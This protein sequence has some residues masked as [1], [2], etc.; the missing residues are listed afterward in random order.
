MAINAVTIPQ[1]LRPED[2]ASIYGG[3]RPMEGSPLP[4]N[5]NMGQPANV[6]MAPVDQNFN[7]PNMGQQMMAPAQTQFG[8]QLM[9]NPQIQHVGDVLNEY[10][11]S[12]TDQQ[13]NGGLTQAILA[14]RFQPQMQDISRSI[15]QTNAAFGAPDL[16]KAVNPQEAMANRYAGEL[17]PYTSMLEAQGKMGTN[18][19]N[20]AGGATGVLINRL[21]SGNPGMSFQQALQQVQTGLRSNTMIDGQGRVVPMNNALNTMMDIN[22][23]KQTGTNISDLSYKPKIAG[24]EAQARTNVELENAAEIEAQ[25]KLGLTAG[26]AAGNLSTIIDQTKQAINEINQLRNHRAIGTATGLSS[27]LPVIPGSAV[28]DFVSRESQLKGQTFL[29]A[30]GALKGGGSITEIEGDKATKAIGRLDR[31]LNEEDYKKALDDLEMVMRQGLA[32]VKTQSGGKIPNPPSPD[33]V[34]QQMPSTGTFDIDSYL[35]EKG[36]Q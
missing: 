24:G 25:K 5:Y 30:Y 34:N 10:I 6:P 4:M 22:N 35:K 26:T 8:Q 19:M 29:Q 18:M 36:L 1:N 15:S 27:K 12:K 20:Q 17:S 11:N 7:V 2:F 31:A 16:F 13:Q 21:M 9:A 28:Q 3:Q 33:Q 14:N 23:A 32:R